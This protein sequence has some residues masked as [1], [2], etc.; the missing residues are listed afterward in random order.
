[1]ER[2]K[3]EEFVERLGKVKGKQRGLKE[4]WREIEERVKIAL[5]NSEK[6]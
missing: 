6:K 1:L 4:E 5:E 3:K 2:A